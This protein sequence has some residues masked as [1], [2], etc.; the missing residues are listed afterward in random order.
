MRGRTRASDG[1]WPTGAAIAARGAW[2]VMAATDA[3][4]GEGVPDWPG[5]AVGAPA[6]ASTTSSPGVVPCAAADVSTA[7]TSVAPMPRI[8]SIAISRGVLPVACSNAAPRA[9]I[10][11]P[12]GPPKTKPPTTWAAGWDFSPVT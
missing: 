5:A 3:D 7:A 11:I 4:A 6:P 2:G 10:A 12:I 1:S 9:A 8:P